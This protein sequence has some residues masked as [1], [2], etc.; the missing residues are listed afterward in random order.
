MVNALNSF[1]NPEFLK[2]LLSVTDLG[3]QQTEGQ[4]RSDVTELADP[5]AAHR[6]GAASADP[7]PDLVVN[8]IVEEFRLNQVLEQARLATGATG[9]AIGLVRGEEIVCRATTGS[10][11]PS[12]GVCLDPRTGLS[13]LCI[14]TRQLQ[15]CNDTETDPRVN[16][17]ACRSMGIRSIAVLPL[18]DGDELF[19]VVEIL[20]SRPNAFGQS[21]LYNLQALTD[22]ILE[23]RRQEWEATAT[24]PHKGSASFLHNLEEVVP[25]RRGILSDSQEWLLA[26]AR[27]GW[28]SE[29]RASSS[30]HRANG[31]SKTGRT[32]HTVPPA[33]ELLT[34]SPPAAESRADGSGPQTEDTRRNKGPA[35]PR[36]VD[37]R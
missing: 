20:S 6:T 5:F 15:H 10:D 18:M 14:R 8:E 27:L 1:G 12:L 28:H 25:A 11:A 9:A 4:A 26:W 37:S 30:P 23:N 33:K 7:A 22:R 29:F 31:P 16:P 17:E 13:G 32:D 21:D 19:G 3:Q 34:G 2:D 36:A 24:L 35:Q